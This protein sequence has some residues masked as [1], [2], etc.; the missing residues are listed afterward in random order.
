MGGGGEVLNKKKKIDELTTTWLMK[1]YVC[2]KGI[3][4]DFFF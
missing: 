1:I 4:R 3:L 2:K